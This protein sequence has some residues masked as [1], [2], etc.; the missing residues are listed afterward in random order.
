[1]TIRGRPETNKHPRRIRWGWVHTR[2]VSIGL[3]GLLCGLAVG[4]NASQREAD[5]Y[6]QAGLT[7]KAHSNFQQARTQFRLA[8]EQYPP[9][10]EAHLELGL[11]LC[12][13]QRYQQAIKHFLR[14]R[15][16]GETSYKPSAYIG[17]A[18]ERLG[19]WKFAERAY[20]RAIHLAPKL[21]DI[22]LRLAD[23]LEWQGKYQHAGAI[24][25]E[26]L[27]L[28]PDLET[29]A[30]LRARAAL[31][32]QPPPEIH[33]A[34]AD[35]Y[36]R[37][38]KIQRG[39][40]E[41]AKARSFNPKVPDDLLQFGIF[42]F[43][44]DQF[45]PAVTYLEQAKHAGGEAQL[46]IRAR[47]AIAYDELG[48]LPEAIQEY[49]AVLRLQPEW[50]E[51]HERLAELLQ[52]VD[53]PA[54]AADELEKLFHLAQRRAVAELDTNDLWK[55]ILHLRGEQLQK[56]VV[57]LNRAG[58][59][60]L[61]QVVINDT[62]PAAVIVDENAK[63]TI[64]SDQLAHDLGIQLTPQTSEFH[65]T[66]AGRP[67]TAPLVNLPSIRVGE[68]EAHNIAA[69]VWSLSDYPGVDGLLGRSFL[70]HF[71]VDI[72]DDQHLLVLTKLYS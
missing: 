6:Y 64:I 62:R 45:A 56:A 65:F 36:V 72:H 40:T 17:Y 25:Q 54:E 49:Q 46:D 1:M 59:Y 10:V 48:Q 4:C 8:I 27:T 38:G 3:I 12:R 58:D 69:L 35:L 66:F 50:Y 21:I 44:R 43:E 39:L 42:C 70:K 57:R 14:A 13:Y 63:Y 31:L 33:L 67:Y 60:P 30:F 11:L 68:L 32:Q 41:Y 47:L 16:Y 26:A 61:I 5:R 24:V 20:K 9:H 18:Y 71:Q 19:R 15:Q 7:A 29:G 51:I 2:S 28:K 52:Q 34:L 23:V 53:R 55:E 37:Q 22:R